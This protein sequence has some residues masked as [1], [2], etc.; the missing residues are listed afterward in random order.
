LEI[1]TH[2]HPH[3]KASYSKTDKN[4]LVEHFYD[5]NGFN[6]THQ[7]SATHYEFAHF[8]DVNESIKV[9]DES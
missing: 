2:K 4:A 3:L 1:I 8:A 9:N 5:K 7:D 6:I